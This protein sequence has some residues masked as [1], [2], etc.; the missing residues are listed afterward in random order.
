[1]LLLE[2]VSVHRTS[3]GGNAR[4]YI[5]DEEATEFTIGRLEGSSWML[6][7]EY[8]SRLQAVIRCVNGMYFLESKGSAPLAINDRSHPIERNRIVRRCQVLYA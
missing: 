2:V 4:R 6:P 3:M 5:R 8:V 1:M 7:Q